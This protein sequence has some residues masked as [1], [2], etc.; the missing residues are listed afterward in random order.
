MNH[1]HLQQEELLQAWLEMSVFIRGNRFLTDFSFNE[2][3]IC[4]LLFRQQELGGAPLTATELCEYTNLLKSQVNHILTG[5]ENRGWIQRVRST[6]D[7]RVVHVHLLESGRASYL[8]EHG[9]VMDIIRT[10][11]DA[12]GTA[13]AQ[14]L[15]ALMKEATSAVNTYQKGAN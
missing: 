2:I 5:M 1:K 12:L 6:Q 7:K 3:M 13:K 15:T 4:G 9:K 11:F 14:E 10:V 8:K